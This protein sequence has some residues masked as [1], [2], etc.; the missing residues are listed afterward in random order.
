MME[1]QEDMEEAPEQRQGN[2]YNHTHPHTTPHHTQDPELRE[3]ADTFEECARGTCNC[4]PAA[5]D[6]MDKS[7]GGP[8]STSHHQP[9]LRRSTRQKK[10]QIA[11]IDQCSWRQAQEQGSFCP[12]PCQGH[13]GASCTNQLPTWE[14][15]TWVHLEHTPGLV[16]NSRPLK[17]ARSIPKG[18]LFTQF[19][20]H[21]L[22]KETHPHAYDTFT[23]LRQRIEREPGHERLQYVV[24]TEGAYWIPPNDQPLINRLSPSS[25]LKALL[26]TTPPTAGLGQYANHSCCHECINAEIAPMVILVENETGE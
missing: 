17:A 26:T 2:T 18:T 8:S 14:T 22:Q 10:T 23:A 20:G 1:V 6:H 9:P 12:R 13:Q 15:E 16:P 19:G 11:P 5:L 25:Q 7:E 21:A 24:Q 3:P 4:C